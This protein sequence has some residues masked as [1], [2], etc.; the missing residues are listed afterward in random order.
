MSEFLSIPEDLA[1]QSI[2]AAVAEGVQ[3]APDA[4]AAKVIERLTMAFGPVIQQIIALIR[5]ARRSAGGA[6]GPRGCRR[7]CR[8]GQRL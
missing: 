3:T 8:P 7:R 1:L 5:S 4:A 6:S 2:A